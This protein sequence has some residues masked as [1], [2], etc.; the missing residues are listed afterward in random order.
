[1]TWGEAKTW[2]DQ[3]SFGAY[4]D[5]RLPSA[6]P[7]NGLAYNYIKA[8]DGSSDFG[9]NISSPGTIYSEFKNNEMAYLYY[10]SLGNLSPYYPNGT[11]GQPNSGFRNSGPFEVRT[12][13]SRFWSGSAY[14]PNPTQGWY[15]DFADGY[16]GNFDNDRHYAWAVRDGDTGPSASVDNP[17]YTTMT[18][19]QT[20]SFDYFWLMG[21]DP[22]PYSGQSF[23]VLALQGGAG[24]QYI[25][26]IAA[27]NSS[28]DWL[29]AMIAV[30]QEFWGLETQIRFVLSDFG[31]GTDPT[32]YL[33]NIASN[34]APVPE[35]ASML[36]FGTGLAC[37]RQSLSLQVLEEGV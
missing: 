19:G 37:F 9:Y 14:E 17:F 28:S 36:L 3:L 12:S 22:P 33:R 16:Q 25:G 13:D 11:G 30:P 26:Q 18:L 32:V 29:T 6:M 24:W 8:Y 20:I 35:P 34:T 21:E 27:Y 10:N 23:D 5:W 4:T 7:V 2:A 1:M 15:F 31:P